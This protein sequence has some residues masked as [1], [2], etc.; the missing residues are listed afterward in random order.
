MLVLK[1]GISESTYI[2]IPPSD[3]PTTIEV[4]VIDSQKNPGHGPRLR[5]GFEA[6]ADVGVYRKEVLEAIA[7]G[8][9]PDPSVVKHP[10][11][12]QLQAMQIVRDE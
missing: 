3:K 12:S 9:V 5:L 8:E 2:I 7:R 4:I 11:P 1:R 6:P 10:S